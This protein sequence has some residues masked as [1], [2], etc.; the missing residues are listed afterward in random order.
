M[1][2]EEYVK[3]ERALDAMASRRDFI[4]LVE[5][6]GGACAARTMKKLRGISVSPRTPGE[7]FIQAHEMMAW[8]NL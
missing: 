4:L 2:L 5:Q 8:M 6:N 1:T 3:I 7:L